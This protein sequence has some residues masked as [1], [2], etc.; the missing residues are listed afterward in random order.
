V[1]SKVILDIETVGADW[2]SLPQSTQ[3]YLLKYQETEKEE[4]RTRGSLAFW[5]PTAKII[6]IGLFNP[7]TKKAMILAEG[8]AG[9]LSEDDR[10]GDIIS[11]TFYGDEADLLTKFWNLIPRYSQYITYNGR[12]FDCPFLMHRSLILG[13]IPSRN[14]D[15]PRYQLSPHLDLLDVLT[16]FGASRKFTLQFWCQT[17]GIEDPKAEFGGGSQVQTA[18]Q[19]GRMNDI[20]R[21]NLADLVATARLYQTVDNHLLSI[22][23]KR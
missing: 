13:L 10:F 11:S 22:W 1:T 17:L 7:D 19:E 3:E 2:N 16:F 23:N 4:E 12:R 20:I 21:Y 6:V 9:T 15:T 18:Y 8:P 5:A 14:L